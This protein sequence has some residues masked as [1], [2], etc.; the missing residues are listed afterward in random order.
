V[1]ERENEMVGTTG[2][3]DERLAS[4]A[5]VVP[6]YN[7]AE[8]LGRALTSVLA[9]SRRPDEIIVVD[10]GSTDSTVELACSFESSIHVV[11]LPHR[12]VSAARN[13]GVDAA[14]SDY[15]AF[16]DSDDYWDERHLER[17]AAA[18]AETNGSA[19]T[20]FS[21]LRTEPFHS[22]STLWSRSGFSVDPPFEVRASGSEWL[23][24]PL[25]PMMVQASVISRAAYLAVGGSDERLRRRGDTH[26]IF[27]LGLTGPVCA[28][29]GVAGCWTAGADNSLTHTVPSSHPTY[30]EST[31]TLYA[32]LLERH[33]LSHFQRRVMQR[34]L[35]EAHLALAHQTG[36]KRP[37]TLMSH[38]RRA[39]RNDPA[40]LPKRLG[41]LVKRSAWTTMRTA[42]TTVA[43]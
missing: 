1:I 29:P 22:G 35:A 43:R 5:V 14:R 2:N 3:A 24:A 27:K 16:L 36:T 21:D 19:S 42:W 20:Y 7:R 12:G 6:T 9:Q 23:F 34:R 28:V 37:L 31:I 25:Q 4:L 18:I 41:G 15:I 38:L 39:L 17:M 11:E 10:D 40:S 13:A 8:T 30:L 33:Q 32:D 26:L